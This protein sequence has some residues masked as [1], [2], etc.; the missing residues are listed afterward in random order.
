[1]S[2]KLLLDSSFFRFIQKIDADTVASAA[3]QACRHC[4][5]PLD[6]A[7]YPRKPRGL[8]PD[9]EEDWRWRPSFCCR[10]DGCRKRS[11]PPLLGFI[12]GRVYVSAMVTLAAA[13][14]QGPTAARVAE[15]RR[16]LGLSPQTVRRWLGWWRDSF[17]S[18]RAWRHQC[19][20]FVPPIDSASL[21]GALLE[22]LGASSSENIFPFIAALRLVT[23]P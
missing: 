16:L 17:P 8:P 18:T 7:D 4:G 13:L 15:L 21:P 5:A 19:G 12:R 1:M 3:V 20:S 6:R 11:S 9:C 2:H 14:C 23:S 22:R 10:R